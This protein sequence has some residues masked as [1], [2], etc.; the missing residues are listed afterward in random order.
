MVFFIVILVLSLIVA[1]YTGQI[2]NFIIPMLFYFIGQS[3]IVLMSDSKNRNTYSKLYSIA[4]LFFLIYAELCYVYMNE[5]GFQCLL[6][7][8][9]ITSY[10]PAVRDFMNLESW[11]DGFGLLYGKYSSHVYS[12]AGIILFYWAAVGKFSMLFGN[13]LY[14]NLQVSV[15][16]LSAFV[17]IFLYRFLSQS[18]VKAPF[19]YSL[20][21][22][23]FSVFFYYSS[24]ILRDAPIALFYMMAFSYLF[25]NTAVKKHVVFILMI[26]LSYLIRP[27]NGFFLLLFYLISFISNKKT[28]TS[29]IVVT[30]AALVIS[31]ISI[32]LDIVEALERNMMY[33]EMNIEQETQGFINLL[34][35][36]PPI[37]SDISKSIYIQLSPIPAWFF[38]GFKG[39]NESNNIMAFPRMMGVVYNVVVLLGIVYGFLHYRRFKF[40]LKKTLVFLAAFLYL[41]LQ[42]S[43][44]EQRRIMICYPI[45]FLFSLL[46]Y[47]NVTYHKKKELI[48]LSLLLFILVQLVALVK[49]F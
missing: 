28:T 16:F 33:A 44:T 19:K 45:L 14:F 24:L 27:Q 38:M 9:T 30:I 25:S 39:I 1:V 49:G 34:D 42:T 36:L 21:Y 4:Y 5:H 12:H 10:I 20:I 13:E 48:Q 3:L 40:D 15:L 23:F 47:Q 29:L 22:P 41:L 43:S 11:K 8:D 37:I 35:K 46:V 18:N 6:A 17:P 26:T 7:T 32:Q 2:S 31:Y